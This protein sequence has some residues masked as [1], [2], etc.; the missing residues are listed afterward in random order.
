[1]LRD[2]VLVV[3][4]EDTTADLVIGELNERRVPVVRFDLAD[5]PRSVA[6]TAHFGRPPVGGS[7]RTGSREADLSAVRAVYYRRP[8]L[9]RFEEL[10]PQDALFSKDQVRFGLGGVLAAL[11]GCRQVNHP[12]RQMAAEY[13]PAQLA[14]AS[15]LGFA[16]PPT[17]VTNRLD[18]ARQF[19]EEQGVAVYKPLWSSDYQEGEEART[20]WVRAVSASE[21]DESLA[22]TPHLFQARVDKAADVR[23]TVVGRTVFC[24]RIDSPLTDWRENYD[25]I[26]RYSVVEPPVG[27]ADL[28]TKYLERFGLAYGCFDFGIDA[29]DG[30]WWWYECNPAGEWGWMASETGLPIASAFADLLVA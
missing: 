14:A 8:S 15:E 18:D 3:T 22:T 4:G 25:L 17:V 1:M 23:V 29:L 5:L 27:L 16:V 19:V 2:T 6:L 12:R 10:S 24:V 9:P 11:P 30:T 13:K 7:L 28:L 21:L 26:Q 20:I